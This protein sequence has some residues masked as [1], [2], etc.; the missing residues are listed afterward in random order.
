MAEPEP[1]KSDVITAEQREHIE[2]LLAW[3]QKTLGI[4]RKERVGDNDWM[5]IVKL[6]A[7]IET[8]LNAALVRQFGAPK[9]ARVIAKLDTSNTAVGKIAF[10]KALEILNPISARR[11]AKS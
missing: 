5:M 1:P 7:M 9:L 2:S 11:N 6:H 10:A 3:M 8:G 4:N